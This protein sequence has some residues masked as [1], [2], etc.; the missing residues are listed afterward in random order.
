V[1]T[2]LALRTVAHLLKEALATKR[3]DDS[4]P[5]LGHAFQSHARNRL[6]AMTDLARSQ[7]EVAIHS[8]DLD[9]KPTVN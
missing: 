7:P 2:Q 8:S 4:K 3:E 9:G 1:V 5:A 6:D